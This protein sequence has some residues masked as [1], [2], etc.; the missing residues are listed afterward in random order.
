MNLKLLNAALVLTPKKLQSKAVA[1]AMNFLFPASLYPFNHVRTLRL[2]VT[3]LK[4]HWR[5]K[6]DSSGC[7][8]EFGKCDV[9]VT[10]RASLDIILAAQDYHQLQ[11]SLKNG[12]IEVIADPQDK[13]L[14][15]TAL[16]K[17]TQARLDSLVERCYAFLKLKPKPRFDIQTVTFADIKTARDVDWVRDQAIKLEDTDLIEALRLME[18]AHKARP[19]GPLIKKKVEKYRLALEPNEIISD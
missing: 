10:V 9:D 3:D 14:V 18:I 13:A 17:V 16:Q 2:E 15:E 1:K 4:R 12:D 7:Q 11:A 19:S 8:P 6:I 5:L